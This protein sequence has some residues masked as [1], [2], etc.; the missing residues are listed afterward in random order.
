MQDGQT[1]QQHLLST[2]LILSFP[3]R[4]H[5]QEDPAMAPVFVSEFYL[6]RCNGAFEREVCELWRELQSPTTT[7]SIHSIQW[8]VLSFFSAVGFARSSAGTV[9]ISC[10]ALSRNSRR[11]G[12]TSA[13]RRQAAPRAL[14]RCT[15]TVQPESLSALSSVSAR[16]VVPI[17]VE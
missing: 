4:L 3:C 9:K 13:T 6:R 8:W 14:Q 7:C 12:A 17:F 1:S 10:P 2:K 11:G 16:G 5:H 15:P